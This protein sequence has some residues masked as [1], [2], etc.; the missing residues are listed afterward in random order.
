MVPGSGTL[1]ETHIYTPSKIP[2]TTSPTQLRNASSNK[3]VTNEVQSSAVSEPISLDFDYK[4]AAAGIIID[5]NVVKK[6]YR[7]V[8]YNPNKLSITSLTTNN[9]DFSEF[10]SVAA[11]HPVAPSSE[12]GILQPTKSSD[13]AIVINWPDPGRVADLTEL[14]HFGNY[15]T[16]ASSMSE[17][18]GNNTDTFSKPAIGTSPSDNMFASLETI[19]NEHKETE[20]EFTDFQ[21]VEPP[22]TSKKSSLSNIISPQQSV[23]PTHAA[24]ARVADV[25][26]SGIPICVG[27]ER[28]VPSTVTVPTSIPQ[29]QS[30]SWSLPATNLIPAKIHSVLHPSPAT[31][32]TKSTILMPQPSTPQYNLSSNINSAESNVNW[33]DPGIDPDEMARL[34]AIFPTPKTIAP[35]VPPANQ[36]THILSSP[37]KPTLKS[38]DVEWTDFVSSTGSLGHQPITNII[39]Q[40]IIKQQNDDDDWSEFVSSA[41]NVT[42]RITGPNFSSWNAPSQFN[43]WSQP[44]QPSV[45]QQRISPFV[46]M[47]IPPTGSLNVITTNNNNGFQQPNLNLSQTNRITTNKK[48]PSISLIPDLGFAAPATLHNRT[49][50]AT[51]ATRTNNMYSKK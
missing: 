46:P 13:A 16:I 17:H 38:D 10:Q 33:P 15:A 31:E 36:Q 12:F 48:S 37:K 7:D 4:E 22:Q 20:D 27:E 44:Y 23:F 32:S 47:Q 45:L 8:E 11:V 29:F 35:T 49:A 1:K 2:Y 30:T 3:S 24:T 26:V 40:N 50:T 43:S 25:N 18:T 21:C 34:E 28:V 9:D 39:N 6:E 19:T 14:D 51:G 5:E 42:N 41:P